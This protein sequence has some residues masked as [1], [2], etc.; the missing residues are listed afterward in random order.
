MSRNIEIVMA[1]A[2]GI[3]DLGLILMKILNAASTCF[4]SP[5][6]PW[7]IYLTNFLLFQAKWCVKTLLLRSRLVTFIPN[8]F[9]HMCVLQY[10]WIL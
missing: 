7:N 4:S 2:Q 3:E 1:L 10:Y 6:I 8:F 5:I 9:V